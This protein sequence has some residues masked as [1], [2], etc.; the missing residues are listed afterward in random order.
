MTGIVNIEAVV[1]NWGVFR[2]GEFLD[3]TFQPLPIDSYYVKDRPKGEV[4]LTF[5]DGSQK[6][7]DGDQFQLIYLAKDENRPKPETYALVE[8]SKVEVLEGCEFHQRGKN[9][10]I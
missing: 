3:R 8:N 1:F 6:R 2:R 7:V 4:Y 9:V 10:G 5:E